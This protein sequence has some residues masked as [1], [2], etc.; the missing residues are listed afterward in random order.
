MLKDVN[1]ETYQAVTVHRA[2]GLEWSKSPLVNNGYE[3]SPDQ[4]VWEG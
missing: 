1:I 4:Y 3:E 2:T